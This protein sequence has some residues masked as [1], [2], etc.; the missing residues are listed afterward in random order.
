MKITL[1][2]ARNCALTLVEVLVVIA[3]LIFL[4]MMLIPV[5]T[6]DKARAQ[7][8][9]CVINLKQIGMATYIWKGNHGDK[10]PQN[11]SATNGGTM[12]FTNGLN[13]WRYFQ[14]ISNELVTPKVLICADERRRERVW[15]TNFLTLNNSNLSYFIGLDASEVNPQGLL[16]GDRNITNGTP[17]KNGIMELT[18]NKPAGWTEKIHKHV[19]N[20]LLSD[21]SV[22]Q[23]S[24]NGLRTAIGNTEVA[25]NRLLM[26]VLTP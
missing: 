14:V 25:T 5:S 17:I 20:L 22:Q 16:S 8:I 2:A 23:L 24:G 7:R 19:G 15:A 1:P 3:I 18:A 21:G 13:A 11:V 26:P 12:E 6:G 10:F 9:Q 4:F